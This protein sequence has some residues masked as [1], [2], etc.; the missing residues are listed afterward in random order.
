MDIEIEK[1]SKMSNEV[2]VID[3]VLFNEFEDIYHAV[4]HRMSNDQERF[5][6]GLKFAQLLVQYKDKGK[7]YNKVYGF[8]ER[9]ATLSTQL[10][11]T[12]WM[13]MIMDR[14]QD[15]QYAIFFDKRLQIMDEA[16]VISMD[17]GEATKNRVDAMK[18]FGEQTKKPDT[19]KIDIEVE[20]KSSIELV[21]RIDS[22][23]KTLSKNGQLYQNDGT[24]TDVDII[25][26]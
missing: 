22:I 24:I 13:T 23:L 18:F 21:G 11:S 10:L 3:E 8:S 6:Q 14:F 16:F 25:L 9:S 2:A 5:M 7:A 20:D 1:E 4:K 15:S 19:I 17:K 12:Q 26:D